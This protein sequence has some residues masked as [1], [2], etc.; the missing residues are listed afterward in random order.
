MFSRTVARFDAGRPPEPSSDALEIMIIDAS[1]AK[2]QQWSIHCS[3]LRQGRRSTGHPAGGESEQ[4]F[5][6]GLCS[7]WTDRC[8]PCSD[9]LT[10][11][12]FGYRHAS[13]RNTHTGLVGGSL[14]GSDWFGLYDFRRLS[15]PS[16]GRMRSNSRRV[17]NRYYLFCVRVGYSVCCSPYASHQ[18]PTG[19][20]HFGNSVNRTQQ[21]PILF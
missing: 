18:E 3:V 14:D 9:W 12:T 1:S 13:F 5:G 6:Y 7:S 8:V 20:P 4:K 19:V 17:C 10:W 16:A 11:W 21:D 15:W 2:P